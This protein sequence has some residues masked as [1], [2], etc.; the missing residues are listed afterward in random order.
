MSWCYVVLVVF[1]W[2]FGVLMV[3]WCSEHQNWC[4]VWWWCSEHD[5][6]TTRTPKHHQ[7]T[8]I[9]PEPH[10]NTRTPPELVFCLV[11]VFWCSCVLP[12]E[13]PEHQNTSRTLEHQKSRTPEVQNTTQRPEN[14]QN[15][16][17]P[18]ELEVRAATQDPTPRILPSGLLVGHKAT[19]Q[20]GALGGV[21]G[22]INPCS[23][24]RGSRLVNS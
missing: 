20:I 17:I 11:V 16:R 3:F 10:Q 23:G 7:N 8:R 21:Q 18:P 24:G 19:F 22:P 4:S 1:W 2:C 15:T 13:P 6:N 9:P 12:P 14:H 5:Q